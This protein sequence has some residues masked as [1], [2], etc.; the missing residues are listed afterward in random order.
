MHPQ[1]I[2]KKPS[3][4]PIPIEP[5][6]QGSESD[7]A[8]IFWALRWIDCSPPQPAP[9]SINP[10]I[11]MD[12]YEITRATPKRYHCS[13]DRTNLKQRFLNKRAGHENEGFWS[14]PQ[15]IQSPLK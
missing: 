2:S 10:A 1:I 6:G 3:P 14:E 15:E 11:E 4:T 5:T 9:Q 8:L 7:K 13:E 12:K